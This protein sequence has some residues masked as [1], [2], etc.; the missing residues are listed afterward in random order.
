MRPAVIVKET[1]DRIIFTRTVMKKHRKEW[2][3]KK[4][5]V[6]PN[7]VSFERYPTTTHPDV[8]REVLSNLVGSGCDFQNSWI[9]SA[10]SF[11]MWLQNILAGRVKTRSLWHLGLAGGGLIIG[12]PCW[13]G[14]VT[15][16]FWLC[17]SDGV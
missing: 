6:K 14:V 16:E 7:I 3:G 12:K 8:L 2:K 10:S 5:F 15:G 11:R 4:V 1:D 9:K 13:D 17:S